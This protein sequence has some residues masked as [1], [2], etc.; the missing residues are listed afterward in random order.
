M[1]KSDAAM[2]TAPR[3]TVSVVA[4]VL[5]ESASIARLLDSLA[6]QTRRPDE[7]VIVDGGSSDGTLQFLQARVSRGDL[8]LIVLSRPGANISAGRNAGILAAQGPAIACTDAG[9]FLEVDWL[10]SLATPLTGKAR[11][12]SGWFVADPVGP[13]ETAL[14]AATLPTLD[15]IDPERFLPSSRSVAFLKDAWEEAGGYPE[16]LDYCEDLV[17]DF[18]MLDVTGPAEFAPRAVARF[19]PRTSL[20]SFARQYYC[21][22][23]GD[24][25]ANLWMLR[26]AVRYAVYV[27][28]G[29]SLV[30]LSITHSPVWSIAIFAGLV[31]MLRRSYERLAGQWHPLS[32]VDRAKAALWVPAIRLVGDFAKMVGYPVGVAW[33]MRARP[34]KWRTSSDQG[35]Y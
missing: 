13:F 10:E 4:T 34:P 17:F 6:A 30:A 16:W 22:A 5:N 8:N 23:R 25:K 29:P 33:R 31:L 28:V 2:T 1:H 12:V 20:Q 18:R 7:V 24:G 14:G 21:Y 26:H 27:V 35:R 15:D 9:V 3:L 11:M 32:R 19:R